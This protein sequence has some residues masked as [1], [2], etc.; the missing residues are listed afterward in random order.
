MGLSMGSIYEFKVKVLAPE[1]IE[2]YYKG[3]FKKAAE[4]FIQYGW[5]H[6]DWSIE[7]GD[8]ITAY[9]IECIYSDDQRHL[10]FENEDLSDGQHWTLATDD[11]GNLIREQ[12]CFYCEEMVTEA[13][14]HKDC[15]SYSCDVCRFEGAYSRD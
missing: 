12:E 2:D 10:T 3:N 9:E 4:L 7:V 5:E 6:Q 15:C 8:I 14:L 1:G 13:V 11:E